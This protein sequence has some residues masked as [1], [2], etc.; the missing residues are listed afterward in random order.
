MKN[1]F[2]VFLT[3][4]IPSFSV[5]AGITIEECV[6]KAE[7]NYPLITK[8]NL[9]ALTN[10]VELSDINKSWLPR[11][12]V[13]AQAT[14]QND[15]PSF[16]KT[17]SGVLEQMGQDMQ[18]L[19]KF[20]YKLGVDVSQTIWDG[21]M[22]R[23]RRRLL[24][25]QAETQKAALDVELY[26]VRQR[27]E[28]IYFAILLTEEQIVQNSV[29]E[30]LLKANLEQLRSMLRN[31]TA[32]QS[33]C[34]MIEAQAIVVSQ[35]ISQAKSAVAG[36][37]QVLSLFIGEN[38][39]N[40][41]L[42]RP[43]AEIPHD[44]TSDRPEL[45]LFE[46]ELVANNAA[47]RLTNTSLMPK[48]GLFAQAYYGYPGFDYFQS[49]MH[50]KLSFNIMAGIKVSWNIDSFYTKKNILK[51]TSLN[52]E[53]IVADRSL[54]LFN[55]NMQYVAQTEAIRGLRTVIKDDA[56]VVALR[57]NVRKA[58]ES[59]LENGVIDANALLSKISDENIAR[60]TA[61]YHE[62]QLLQEIYKLKYIVNR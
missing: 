59:Q 1:I 29:V 33:D 46:N 61:K 48:V 6:A 52:A 47:E 36:Y 11:L 7:D 32:M 5:S 51:K 28:N 20:Q 58:A 24:R 54:F 43:T 10:D 34:D 56:R 40:Q 30:K 15:V 8:Y 19:G 60:L 14:I 41:K 42:E 55:S 27:V 26:N 16:P 39:D 50:R 57:T 13:Y 22:A 62:I 37:R 35:N 2:A 25:S 53:N 18:G 23:S 9:V 17:L 38:I 44:P 49:M 31:G 45:R 4:L 21:G 3:C 12:G